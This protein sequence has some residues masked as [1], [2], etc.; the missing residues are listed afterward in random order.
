MAQ[1]RRGR[2]CLRCVYGSRRSLLHTRQRAWRLS[3]MTSSALHMDATQPAGEGHSLVGIWTLDEGY[4]ITELLLRSDGNYQLDT[5]SQNSDLDYSLTE[6]G[7]YTVDGGNFTLSPYDYFGEPE[8][9][10]F[11]FEISGET[12]TLR[13]SEYE[14]TYV[15]QFKPGST[16]DVEARQHIDADLIGTWIRSIPYSG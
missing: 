4:Q 13:R 16:A 7:H 9:K 15:Y 12:L 5:N 3:G 14:L 2:G 10:L 11:Q 6:R 8:H 1:A